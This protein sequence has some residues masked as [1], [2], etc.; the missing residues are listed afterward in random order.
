MV[1]GRNR[2]PCRPL[3]PP[4]G[5]GRDCRLPFPRFRRLLRRSQHPHTPAQALTPWAVPTRNLDVKTR[6]TFSR[7]NKLRVE[8]LP[9]LLAAVRPD[10][11]N[12]CAVSV[13][14][15]AAGHVCAAILSQW[16][17]DASHYARNSVVLAVSSPKG[18]NGR[19]VINAVQLERRRLH[20]LLRARE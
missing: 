10:A 12:P 6:S 17:E 3:L 18:A 15:I 16:H 8:P 9:L 19:C 1:F 13:A 5:V 7:G 4:R 14:V 2:A 20:L 11:W